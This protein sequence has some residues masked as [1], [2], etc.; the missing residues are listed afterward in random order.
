MNEILVLGKGMKFIPT[1][2]NKYAKVELMRDVNEYIR[3]LRCRFNYHKNEKEVLHPLYTQTGHVSPKGNAALENYITDLK[4]IISQIE[5]N[6]NNTTNN[7]SIEERKAL[8]DLSN[9]EEILITKA[10]KNNTTV[11]ID[12]TKYIEEDRKSVV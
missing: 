6:H 11:V 2:C 7:M 1:P 5:I 10:D 3:K 8:K 4:L 12:K 9:N